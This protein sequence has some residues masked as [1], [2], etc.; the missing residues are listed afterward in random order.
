MKYHL[1]QF[2]VAKGRYPID[3]PGMVEF[4]AQ[5]LHINSLADETP[6]F[7]W[8]L[9]DESGSNMYIHPF[10]EDHLLMVTFSVWETLEDVFNFTYKGQHAATM[11][12]RKSWFE[13]I[14]ERYVVL[15]WIPAGHIPTLEEAKDHLAHI[16][17]HGPTP[18]AFDF[19]T[20]F[21]APD[22]EVRDV[23]VAP[24]EEVF[25][26]SPKAS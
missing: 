12:N 5:L 9:K 26:A 7:V 13:H 11:K 20:R 10:E 15:W 25:G 14:E 4:V 8:R 24:P 6:G 23:P 3:H 1:A 22:S 17:Q 16:R 21:P 19:K 18:Y 2:N